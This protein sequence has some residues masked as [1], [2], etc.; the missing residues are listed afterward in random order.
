MYLAKI[1]AEI[2]SLIEVA[3]KNPI[4]SLFVFSLSFLIVLTLLLKW[5]N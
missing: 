1:I 3:Q 4:G 5:K 2:S